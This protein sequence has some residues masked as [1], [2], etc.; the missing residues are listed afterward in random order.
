MIALLVVASLAGSVALARF[1]GMGG[2]LAALDLPWGT[3]AWFP[4]AIPTAA[5]IGFALIAGLRAFGL[6]RERRRRTP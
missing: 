5:P 4:Q 2:A 1:L 3:F 6:L